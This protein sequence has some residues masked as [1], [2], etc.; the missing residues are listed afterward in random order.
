MQRQSRPDPAAGGHDPAGL[1][2]CHE[3][4]RPV[5]EDRERHGLSQ[6]VARGEQVLLGET[7]QFTIA[8]D[9]GRVQRDAQAGPVALPPGQA[10]A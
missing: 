7:G 6:F 1:R 4:R 5:F 3:D 10:A 9:A 8:R 2:A